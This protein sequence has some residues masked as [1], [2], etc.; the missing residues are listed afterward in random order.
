MQNAGT[1]E[2]PRGKRS[3][4]QG[5][6]SFNPHNPLAN[7]ANDYDVSARVKGKRSHSNTNTAHSNARSRSTPSTDMRSV[8]FSTTLPPLAVSSGRRRQDPPESDQPQSHHRR[9]SLSGPA[10]RLR[11]DNGMQRVA[12]FTPEAS[13][14]TGK[15]RVESVEN[16]QHP[17]GKGRVGSPVRGVDGPG[18]IV[19]DDGAD[20][21][22]KGDPHCSAFAYYDTNVPAVGNPNEATRNPKQW[23]PRM[24][25]SPEH[26]AAS[27]AEFRRGCTQGRK[28]CTQVVQT[29]KR[30][31]GKRQVEGAYISA[32]PAARPQRIRQYVAHENLTTHMGVVSKPQVQSPS[33]RRPFNDYSNQS[34][35]LLAQAPHNII[36]SPLPERPR[37]YVPKVK[38]F[39]GKDVGNVVPPPSSASQDAELARLRSENQGL[40]SRLKSLSRR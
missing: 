2:W 20:V 9:R 18:V 34:N 40:L 12:S 25:D 6:A 36:P 7:T 8:L 27:V 23:L 24:A 37:A 28:A 13:T 10:N 3:G 38:R 16:T 26:N 22:L 4:S 11:V 21:V 1:D 39:E 31:S 14:P 15:R 29:E 17:V 35:L 30:A 32:I 19:V 5:A 33:V